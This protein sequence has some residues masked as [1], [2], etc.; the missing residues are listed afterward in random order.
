MLENTMSSLVPRRRPARRKQHFHKFR[1][2]IT[3]WLIVGLGFLV[4]LNFLNEHPAL[5]NGLVVGV[6]ILLGLLLFRKAW[7]RS[8]LKASRIEEVD[9]LSGEDFERLLQ[10]LF[11][12]MGYKAEL[13]KTSGDFGADV[14]L[15]DRDG[16]RLVVQAKRWRGAVGL[17]AVQEVVA[18]IPVYR[19]QG[20][21][22]VTNSR[23]T[24]AAITL[25]RHNSIRL[26]GRRDLIKLL[27]GIDGGL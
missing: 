13:T 24:S 20:G 22:V 1:R 3:V 12:R 21:L 15:T 8:R 17:T 27:A 16:V 25:A 4:A 9:R 18:A 14:V 6:V 23:F 19:A 11:Q 5:R 7:N 26:I 10:Q 2:A